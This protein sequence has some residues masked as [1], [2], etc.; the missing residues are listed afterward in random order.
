MIEHQDSIYT[1]SNQYDKPFQVSIRPDT[2]IKTTFFQSKSRT[3][4]TAKFMKNKVLN[5]E[6]DIYGEVLSSGEWKSVQKVCGIHIIRDR[7]KN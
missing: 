4:R 6:Q 3:S 1:D 5:T 2:S 7:G